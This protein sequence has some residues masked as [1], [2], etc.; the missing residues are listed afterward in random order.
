MTASQ[1]SSSLGIP[2]CEL[3]LFPATKAQIRVSRTRTFKQWGRGMT[4]EEYLDRDEKSDRHDVA[5]DGRLVTWV[6]ARRDAPSGIDFLCS[7]ETFRRDGVVVKPESTRLED[8]ACYGIASVFTPP[9][10]RGKGYARHMMRLLHWVL[11]PESALPE[12]PTDMWGARPDRREWKSEQVLEGHGA[13]AAVSVLYSDVGREFYAGCGVLPTGGSASG[14]TVREPFSTVW[15]VDELV[16]TL[17]PGEEDWQWLD[18]KGLHE[19]WKVDAEVMKAEMRGMGSSAGLFAFLPDKGVADF[20]VQRQK[21]F[22]KKKGVRPEYWGVCKGGDPSTYASWTIDT[23]VLVIT[24]LRAAMDEMEGLMRA[25][26]GFAKRHGVET[27][28]VWG[29]GG[30]ERDE[31]LSAAKWYGDGDVRWCFN[32]K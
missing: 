11:A 3:S 26:A 16:E 12:F 23:N 32:E 17:G 10:N 22:W 25:V 27:M 2:L 29:M 9:E 19:L 24:R 4:L 5:K 1:P 14:W 7:C 30:K 18:E 20:Q 8:A 31:H 28:E 21:Y 13:N 15:K 6:L